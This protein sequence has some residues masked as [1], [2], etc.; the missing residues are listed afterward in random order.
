MKV[1]PYPHAEARLFAVPM[2]EVLPA[3]RVDLTAGLPCLEIEYAIAHG[4]P[5]PHV[6]TAIPGVARFKRLRSKTGY[7]ARRSEDDAFLE[8]ERARVAEWRADKPDQA[9][10]QKRKARAE[11]YNRPFVA[12]DSEGQNYPGADLLYDGVRYAQHATYLWG[13]AA[14]N[15]RP[16]HWLSSAETRGTDKKPLGATEIMDWLLDLPREFGR[17]VYALYSGG[18]DVTQILRHLPFRS[19]GD[20]EARNVPGRGRQHEADRPCAGFLEGICNLL[21]E[22]EVDRHLAACQSR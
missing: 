19:L 5:L 1:T 6:P 4:L 7:R 22:R 8:G 3:G 14:D 13:A 16:P 20:R 9:R 10:A 11:N 2:V 12:I 15:G 17:A 21:C 18:Y